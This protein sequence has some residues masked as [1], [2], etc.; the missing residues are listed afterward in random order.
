MSTFIVGGLVFVMVLNVIMFFVAFRM[1]TDKLTDITYS[2]SFFALSA[3]AFFIGR[4]W[5]SLGKIWIT[6]LIMIGR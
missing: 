4:G 6:A 2:L 5:E 1:Q 3:F